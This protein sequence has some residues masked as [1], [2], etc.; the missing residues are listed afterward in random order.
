MKRF[1]CFL[2]CSL[3]LLY[4]AFGK[5][6][7]IR[8]EYTDILFTENLSSHAVLLSQQA[9]E[10]YTKLAQEFGFTLRFRPKVYLMGDNDTANGYANPLTNTIVIYVN[11]IDPLIMTPNYENWAVFCFAHELSHLFLM[12]NFASYIEPL[13]I[14]GHTVASAVQTALTPLYLHEGL[15]T[16]LETR[17][18]DSGRGVDP[19]FKVYIQ[20]AKSSDIGLRYASSLS[21]SRWLP[22]G[23]SYV[24]GY[25]LLSEVEQ[26][27]SHEKVME[28]IQRFS[29]DPLKP[30][31]STLKHSL[32]E[33]FLNDWLKKPSKETKMKTLSE[34]LL[35]P[36]KVD[37][38]AWRIYY[39]GKKYNG[40]EGLYYYDAIAKQTVKVVDINNSVS[41]SVSK[42]GTFAI[43]RYVVTD[44]KT[45]S[46]LYLHSRFTLDTGITGAVDLAWLDDERLVLIRQDNGRRFI[47]LY[48]VKTNKITRLL[49]SFE[50]LIPLQITADSGKV[51]FTAK[52]G[53]NVD[54]FTTRIDGKIYR[55]TWD[56]KTK[57]SPKVIQEKL[58]F[59]C[60]DNGK[61]QA[62]LLDLKD[63]TLYNLGGENLVSV[64]NYENSLYGFQ[65]TAEGYRF[66]Q[67]QVEPRPIEKVNAKIFDTFIAVEEQNLDSDRFI[68]SV[69]PRFWF[70]AGYYNSTE[71]FVGV[72]IGF[73]NDLLN[74]FAL[75][76]VGLSGLDGTVKFGLNSK[77][78]VGMSFDFDLAGENLR[79]GLRFTYPFTIT[80]GL[81]DETFTIKSG[82][83]LISQDGFSPS[84]GWTYSVGKLGGKLHGFATPETSLWMNLL[85]ALELGFS[86]SFLLKNNLT[87]FTIST[88]FETVRYGWRMV[89]PRIRFDAGSRDGFWNFDGINII[90]GNTIVLRNEEFD[91]DFY[92]RSV[93]NFDIFYQLPLPFFI[94]FG[95]DNNGPYFKLGIEDILSTLNL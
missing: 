16:Y 71:W 76:Q 1:F 57:L 21:T 53:K 3:H 63:H 10:I 62:F 12:N 5:Y 39:L 82:L 64:L 41:F 72:V 33:D 2:I 95:F 40:E 29:A 87:S 14:F 9:D 59:C 30:F 69:R 49:D 38:N 44:S 43:L 70:P 65:I 89:L 58:Y 42:S 25:S 20:V 56:G 36:S 48:D 54:L 34:I 68:D 24:Q 8:T 6:K 37:I 35:W 80:R 18:T 81:R 32:G 75:F 77:R 7:L 45:V 84:I 50:N 86:R 73:S 83:S 55:L 88:D 28:I 52:V 92:M 46:R 66:V 61:L 13:S 79:M 4:F 67:H 93:L 85:P 74:E 60:E 91:F 15:A 27:H 19:L 17:L 26:K 90:F 51:F 22:G 23:A 31:E 78:S 94:T 11:D 47:D